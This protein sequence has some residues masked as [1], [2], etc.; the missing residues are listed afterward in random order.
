MKLAEINNLVAAQKL[1]SAGLRLSIVQHLTNI[2]TNSARS[3]WYESHGQKPPNGKLPETSLYFMETS[4]GAARISAF[5]VFYTQIY[6]KNYHVTP[7]RLISSFDVFVKFI[8]GF[9]INAAYRVIKDLSIGFVSLKRCTDCEAAF[10]YTPEHR[11]ANK[12]PFCIQ[13]G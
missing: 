12:C 3:L 10:I 11:R 5:A 1:I 8:P 7:E 6:D 2:T 9:D 4:T 13:R